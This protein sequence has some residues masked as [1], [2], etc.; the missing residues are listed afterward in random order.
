MPGVESTVFS[1]GKSDVSPSAWTWNTSTGLAMSRSR[2]EPMGYQFNAREQLRGEAVDEDLAAVAC[3][4]HPCRAVQH[5]AEVVLAA[6]LGL[7][8]GDTHSH[9]QLQRALR[10]DRS[11]D[12]RPWRPERRAH[13]VTGVFEQ[14]T[15]VRRNG[16]DT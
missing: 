6:Q 10:G 14:P 8:G 3:R 7:T 15:V 13:P 2:R 4:H 5:D 9:G 11:V 12:G 16:V 1:G